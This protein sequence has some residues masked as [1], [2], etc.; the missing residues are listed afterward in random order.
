MYWSMHLDLV[1]AEKRLG[2]APTKPI[3]GHLICVLLSNYFDLLLRL[4]FGLTA[5]FEVNC[6][7]PV[8][9]SCIWFNL[10]CDGQPRQSL[11]G[12][13]QYFAPVGVRSTAI[14]V[15]PWLYVC[16][17]VCICQQPESKRTKF[18][19]HIPCCS[20]LLWQHWGTQCTSGSMDIVIFAH[21][22]PDKDDAN[23]GYTLRVTRGGT[24]PGLSC[25]LRLLCLIMHFVILSRF[26]IIR[27]RYYC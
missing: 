8:K 21:N 7:R 25:C 6:R 22:R 9:N 11:T 4:D 18:S 14:S 23:T 13:H 17:P 10:L 1:L 19:M 12:P 27:L 26:L 15:S 3:T 5:I 2:H 16:L 20:V 24:A